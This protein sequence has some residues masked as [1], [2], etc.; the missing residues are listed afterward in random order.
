MTDVPWQDEGYECLE[1]EIGKNLWRLD[2]PELAADERRLLADHVGI[3]DACRLQRDLESKIG[4]G[5]ADGSL[6]LPA[7]LAGCTAPSRGSGW[8]SG[9]RSLGSVGAVA[10]AASLALAFILPPVPR[11]QGLVSR[12][13]AEPG[14]IR[15]VEGEVVSPKPLRIIWDSIPGATSYELWVEDLDRKFQWRAET[16]DNFLTMPADI[17]IPNPADFRIMLTPVPGDLAPPGGVNVSFRTAGFGDFVRYRLTAAAR[18]PRL[19]FIGGLAAVLGSVIGL[20]RRKSRKI[21]V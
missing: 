14:F 7:D 12:S 19:L 9:W 4:R 15:P 18:P 21:P 8:M 6:L 10:V 1:P 17:R 20:V 3:C 2:L 5:L 13:G 11:D 16:H